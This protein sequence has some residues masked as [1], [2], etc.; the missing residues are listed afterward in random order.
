M[1]P[2]S[3]E[4]TL[5]L[6]DLLGFLV[7]GAFFALLFGAASAIA[8]FLLTE[9]QPP[10]YRAEATLLVARTAP[11]GAQLGVTSVTAPPIELSAY[12]IVAT[13]D[14]VLADALV[15]LDV[16]EPTLDDLRAL[17]GRIGTSIEAGVR[18]SS[19]LRVEAR[20]GTA[21]S[22]VAR[23]NAVAEALVA[24][25]RR[26]AR[27]SVDRVINTLLQQID[28]LSEQIRTL[29][30]IDQ[31]ADQDRVDG[32]IRL[33]AE[34]QQQLAYARA[35]V[36]S[37]EG[38]MSVLQPADSTPRQI[39]PRPVA[40]AIIAALVA[41]VA[42][43]GL[44]L[45][46]V[47]LNIR[48]RD[49]DDIGRVTGLPVL[50][51]FPSVGKASRASPSLREASSYLRANLLFATAD[52]HPKVFMVTSSV[53]HEGKTTVARYLAE[54]FVRYGYQTLLV[55]CDL[56]SPSVIGG[57]EVIGRIPEEATTESWL[58]DPNAAHH[59][60]SI[61]V[62]SD[63]QLDAIPQ[64]RPVTNASELVGRGIRAVLARW[65][66]YDVVVIDTPP[67]LA[68]ADPLSVAPHCSGTV[69]VVDR[70]RTDRR[71]LA[72]TTASLNRI[73]V[74]VLGVVVNHEE[75]VSG[76]AGYGAAYGAHSGNKM[77][78]GEA[79]DS[80]LAQARASRGNAS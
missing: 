50:A 8:T 66:E 74:Q 12:R 21:G 76:G 32:L 33:R 75:P 7:R 78:R 13:S 69:V 11:T 54:G 58:R 18:D 47:A 55:D 70:S 39:A 29:Q 4:V 6:R 1:I 53:E 49:L 43:Y 79:S 64:L 80:S 3:S 42:T 19:L 23:A 25:D 17:R 63:G 22:A 41:V 27:E 16:P 57:Y 30:T 73:G 59:V 72:Q 15:L 56:R 20:G 77:S 9:Q 2:E 65:S 35:L 40:S 48:L 28:G 5:N 38:M 37:A 71:K 36:A 10:T 61:K 44:L 68:V 45:V 34:Q 60:L 24:W 51:Q 14:Q 46:R 31:T 26:R 52:T 67:V 62:G